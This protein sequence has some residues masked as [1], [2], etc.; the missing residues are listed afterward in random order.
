LGNGSLFYPQYN[1]VHDIELKSLNMVMEIS[2]NLTWKYHGNVN[3]GKI[4][5]TYII[6]EPFF[7]V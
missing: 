1:I 7:D 3:L 5:R 2:G 4:Y 6:Y